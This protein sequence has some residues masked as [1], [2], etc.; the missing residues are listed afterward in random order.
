MKLDVY[1]E[2]IVKSTTQHIVVVSGAGSGKTRV[3]TERIKW[4]IEQ[5]NDPKKIVAITFTNK[6]YL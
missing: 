1:Q 5:G 3:L 2:E 4:L 6:R